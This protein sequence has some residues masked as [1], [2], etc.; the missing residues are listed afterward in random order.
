MDSGSAKY[1]DQN[2]ASAYTGIKPR[3]LE[4]FRL[5]GGGPVYFKVGRRVMYSLEELDKWMYSLRRKNT[6]DPGNR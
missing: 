1:L 5:R 4:S 3:T 6:S 2:G